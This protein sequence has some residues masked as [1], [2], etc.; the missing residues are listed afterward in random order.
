MNP[1]W[2][3]KHLFKRETERG[4]TPNAMSRWNR[5]KFK[6][7]GL[8]DWSDVSTNKKCKQLLEIGRGKKE[9]L[10]L[11]LQRECGPANIWI[12]AETS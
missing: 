2:N 6:D 8:K 9:I 1:K 4:L 7:A 11:N 5:E 3:H 12:S 10:P